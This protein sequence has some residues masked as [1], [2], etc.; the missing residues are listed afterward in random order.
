MSHET[1]DFR[2]TKLYVLKRVATDRL[3]WGCAGVALCCNTPKMYSFAQETLVMLRLA[4]ASYIARKSCICRQCGFLSWFYPAIRDRITVKPQ[5]HYGHA[6]T[7]SEATT[8]AQY[9]SVSKGNCSLSLKPL[10]HDCCSSRNQQTR[11]CAGK[12]VASRC[13]ALHTSE[14]HNDGARFLGNIDSRS[15]SATNVNV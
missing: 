3:S 11:P 12:S 2:E 10:G 6:Y 14:L 13:D 4:E 8:E 1:Y 5:G 9:A 15:D 7:S